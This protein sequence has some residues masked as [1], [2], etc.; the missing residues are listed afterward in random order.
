[1]RDERLE[2]VKDLVHSTEEDL[3]VGGELLYQVDAFLDQVALLCLIY[4]FRGQLNDPWEYELRV[5]LV[6]YYDQ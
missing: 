6:R 1:M 5:I 3:A 4:G 2:L